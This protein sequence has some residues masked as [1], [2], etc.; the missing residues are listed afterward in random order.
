MPIL[1]LQI[2]YTRSVMPTETALDRIVRGMQRAGFMLV[3][4]QRL[5]FAECRTPDYTARILAAAEGD[6]E[7]V[8]W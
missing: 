5:D 1:M 7:A 6:E 2:C 3:A 8:V 4:V